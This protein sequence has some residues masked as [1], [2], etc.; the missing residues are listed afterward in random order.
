MKITRFLGRALHGHLDL[1]ISFFDDLTFITGKNG[2]GKTTVLNLIASVLLPRP[3]YLATGYFKQF[4]V[5]LIHNGE[6]VTICVVKDSQ[7]TIVTC[8]HIFGQELSI[9]EFDP[10]EPI[11]PHRYQELSEEYYQE[12]LIRN[13][14]NAVLQYIQGL[15][16]PMYLGL[17]RRPLSPTREMPQFRS[18]LRTRTRSRSARSIFGR[19]IEAGLDTAL[20]YAREHIF[21]VR[22]DEVALDARFRERL[23]LELIDFPPIS[24]VGAGKFERPSEEDLD[25]FESAKVN[26]RRFP[27][28]LNIDPEII[29]SKIDPAIQFLDETLDKVE[30][31]KE[32]TLSYAALEWSVNSINFNKLSTLSDIISDYNNQR[33]RLRQRINNYLKTTNNFMTD[34]GKEIVFDDIGE[35]RFILSDDGQNEERYIYALSSGEIQMI[36]ILT[37]LYFNPEVERANVF[38]IDEPELSLHVQWQEKFVDGVMEASTETQFILATHSPTIILDKVDHCCEI[39]KSW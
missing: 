30:E 31:E 22:R 14:E 17:D 12:S 32:D 39:S 25:R 21:Q 33:N 19:S 38:I 6:E 37:H 8:S 13:S 18:G 34:N 10:P 11:P 3:D 27:S 36:V 4:S 15:P 20:N 1:D 7:H 35:I 2:S 28:L 29:S 24:I 5:D 26:L 16:V 23:V 9:V